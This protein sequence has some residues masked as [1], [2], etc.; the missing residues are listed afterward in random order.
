MRRSTAFDGLAVLLVA[1]MIGLAG[2]AQDESPPATLTPTLGGPV[3][4]LVAT[5]SSPTATPVASPAPTGDAPTFTTYR[6][7]SGVFTLNFPDDWEVIDES[8]DQRLLVRLLPPIGYGSRATVDIT[9]EGPLPPQEVRSLAE[10]YLRLHYA[11]NPAY[12]E[13]NRAELPDGRLQFVFLY[14]DGRGASGR[15]TLYIQQVGPYFAALRVFLSDKDTIFL[16]SALDTLVASFSVDALAVWGSQVAAINPAELLLVNT[17]LWRGDDGLTY[18]M[19][20]V[21]NASPADIMNVRVRVAICNATGV[22]LAE[23]GGAAALRTVQRGDSVPFS[24]AVEGLPA[25]VEVCLEQAEAEPARPDPTYTRALALDADAG[26]DSRGNLVVR[27]AVTNPEL[28][29]VR[30]VEVVIVVYDPEGRVVGYQLL[31]LGADLNLQPGQ[32]LGF[33]HV[34]T[35]LGGEPE[36]YMTFAQAEVL[37]ASSPSLAPGETP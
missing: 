30:N 25:E 3:L 14:D 11:G 37:S 15:E 27:G 31:P 7:R 33:E 29:P 18:Y 5:P 36:R 19:G 23:A 32:S 24:L 20:E 22:V 4:P 16:G 13:I 8:T 17:S 9:N 21:Y 10:S 34:F 2:C 1:L 35:D 26:L 12:A 6:H 28:V